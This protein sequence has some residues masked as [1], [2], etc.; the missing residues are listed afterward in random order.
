MLGFQVAIGS[1]NDVVDAPLDA[2]AKPR[3]P[4][5]AGLVD[6]RTAVGV[7]AGGALVGIALSAVSGVATLVVGA[8]WGGDGWV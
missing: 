8:A 1:L 3:K 2:T 5:A 7:A 4:I 6:P